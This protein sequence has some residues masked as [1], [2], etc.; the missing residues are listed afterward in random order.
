MT[1]IDEVHAVGLYGPRGGGIAER[2]GV[3]GPDRRDRGHAGQGVRRASAATSPAS[4][5]SS[6][7]SARYAPGFIFTTAL[8]PAVAAA[9]ETSVRH[10][11]ASADGARRATSARSRAP[12]LPLAGAGLPV[13]DTPTH[14]VPLM[15]RD[16]EL[17]KAASD[18]LL[19]RHGL[20]IQPIN[21]PTVPRGTERLRITPTPFHDDALIAGL[22]DR[23]RRG[24]DGTSAC[25]SKRR[26]TALPP[27]N[28]AI[29]TRHAAL[30]PAKPL[31]QCPRRFGTPVS[32]DA[33]RCCRSSVVE[34]SLGKGE[35][36]S[37]ILSGST[38]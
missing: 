25:P 24:V 12:R 30:A 6:T 22:A 5:P 2:D 1:Y 4:A 23:A 33:R 36:E 13:L 10:L 29:I 35:V 34:H 7:R 16:P 18:R 17:C 21:Y 19:E 15:V 9:A 14:I 26:P 31:W 20:Y 37:S 38:S 27:S 8:P 11:K 28:A 3:D 32:G